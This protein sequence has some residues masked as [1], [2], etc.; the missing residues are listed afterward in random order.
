M[1]ETLRITNVLSDET[2]LNIYDYI[3]KKHN[4]V[5]VQEIA[6]T[7]HIHPNVARLHLTKLED[8]GMIIGRLQKNPKGGRPFRIYELSE[9]VIKLQF[10]FRDYE[11]LAKIALETLLSLGEQ[12]KNALVETGRKFGHQIMAKTY[13]DLDVQT[14]TA[15][16]KIKLLKDASVMLGLEPEFDYNPSNDTY[17][18]KIYNCPFK[19]IAAKD[20]HQTICE[21][22]RYFIKG[23]FEELFSNVITLEEK[24]NMLNECKTCGY[25]INIKS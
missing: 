14:L 18:Y 11:M 24:T 6:D 19:E 20:D 23:M 8:I 9:E 7:F 4:S 12:G 13:P 17:T 15:E 10:P 22:H 1:E 5:N 21:M 2:R 16:E 25:L 3:A